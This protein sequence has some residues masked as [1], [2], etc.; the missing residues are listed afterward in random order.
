[1]EDHQASRDSAAAAPAPMLEDDQLRRVLDALP[2]PVSYVDTELRFRYNNRAYDAWVGRP[3]EELWGTH[4]RETLGEKAYAEVLPYAEAALAGREASFEK[5]LEYPGG[6]RRYVSVSY[7]PD[8]DSENRVRGFVA[9]VRD[10]TSRRSA[11]GSMRFQAHLLDTV[12]QAVIATDLEG[13]ITYWNR[14]AERLYGWPAAEA[15]G[16]NV[17]E[18]TP[19]ETSAEQGAE[20]M[21]RLKAGGAWSGEFVVRRRD[22]T[23]FPALVTDAPI[24]DDAGRLVG[25]VGVSADL[26]ERK[27]SEAAVHEAERRALKEYETLLHRL[28][29]LAES[30]GTAR[31]HLTIFR[32]LRDFAVVSVPC[33]GIF[34][35]LYDEAR[36]VRVAR[37][38]WGD[39]EEVD[40]SQ[41]PPMPVTASGPNS[42]AVRTRQVV[43]TN[44][45]WETKQKGRGQLGVLVGPDN[46]LR[47]QSSLVVPMATMG[48]IVGTVEVQSYE[49]HAYR[50]EHVTAM[51]MAANLAAVAIENMRLLQFETRARE[52]AEE[53]N[54]LK[55]EFLATLSHELRTPLTAILGW[56]SMLRDTRLDEKTFKTAVEIVERNARTQQQIVDDILD[57]SRIITGHLRLDAGPTDLR[58]VV[59]AAVD[60]VGPAAAAKSISLRADFEPG[61]GPVVGD[62]RRLQQ[63]VWNLLLNAVKFTPIGGEVRAHLSREGSHARL[64]VTDTGAGIRP[65]FL[66]YVFDRFRQ[67]D[68]STTRVYG[69]LGLGLAIVRHLVELHG[70]TV[71]ASSPG[72]GRGA[73]FTVELPLLRGAEQGARKEDERAA[74]G[75]SDARTQPAAILKGVSVLVVDDEPDALHLIKAVLEMRGAS[76]TAVGSAEAAWGALEE[77]WPDLLVCDIGMPGEDGYQ[78][79]RRLRAS[80][81]RGPTLPS[82]AL[83]AYAGEGDRALALEA[84]Y[85]LHV[86]KPVDPA[87]LVE[88]VADLTGRQS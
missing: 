30:L 25:V 58:Q 36:D 44:D 14:Y 73:T 27:R 79:I 54:R 24:H 1:M 74:G 70:G 80:A 23:C 2:T 16:R 45:Y 83:T 55:D 26:S 18:V 49:N 32:D 65:D 35:S 17:L 87:A 22:G 34:I 76:V 20:I 81:G 11:E 71:R 57:V 61:V 82:V 38:A 75:G 56:A 31:D 62:A 52:S 19:A 29:H 69:G 77:A 66:P 47:P 12:E 85:Q 60:T 7:V 86:P 6:T 50:E 53:A 13:K 67:G 78:L 10:L 51:R 68:Q 42:R 59:A 39:G 3:H 48:R 40:V 8:F 37:Y 28:T 88:V 33:I 46:G 63:V 72:E 41:L 9:H 84:G 4:I 21:A 5:E 15:V 64:A 43:I